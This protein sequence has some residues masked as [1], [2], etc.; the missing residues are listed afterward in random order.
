[1]NTV[2]VDRATRRASSAVRR[3][4]PVRLT[5]RG[6]AVVVAALL[7]FAFAVSTLLGARSAA[8]PTDSA[9]EPTQIIT[10]EAGE[11]LWDI[12]ARVAPGADPRDTIDEIVRLN[13]LDDAGDLQ[14]GQPIVVPTGD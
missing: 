7:L 9:P 2:A 5:R 4:E 11:T 1:M 13:A 6:Q 3:K 10:V 8:V 12:A 14:I